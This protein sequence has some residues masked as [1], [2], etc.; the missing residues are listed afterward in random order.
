MIYTASLWGTIWGPSQVFGE[1]GAGIG[2]GLP[3][4]VKVALSCRQGPV[5]GDLPE[6]MY[7]YSGVGH[8]GQAC[9]AE[10]VA[11]EVFVAEFGHDF[12]P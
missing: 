12:V 8:P 7:G 10:V 9:V 5:S 2:Y 4:R 6:V 3:V 11:A 1:Q